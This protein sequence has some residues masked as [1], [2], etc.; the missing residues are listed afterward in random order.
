MF[1][2]KTG[3]TNSYKILHELCHKFDEDHEYVVLLYVEWI[4]TKLLTE[5]RKPEVE[6]KTHY[7][8]SNKWALLV[9]QKL[10]DITQNFLGDV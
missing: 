9:E 2:Q 5:M 3:S 1:L 10:T 4:F 8:K 6:K 7:Y